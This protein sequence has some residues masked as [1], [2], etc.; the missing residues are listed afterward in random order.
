[1]QDSPIIICTV[2]EFEANNSCSVVATIQAQAQILYPPRHH[3]DLRKHLL[4]T[5]SA[6]ALDQHKRFFKQIG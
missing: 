3:P 4:V 2:V 1:M 5:Q 6:S